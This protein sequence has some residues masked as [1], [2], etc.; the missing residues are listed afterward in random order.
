MTKVI[1]TGSD[2]LGGCENAHPEVAEGLAETGK[3]RGQ[4]GRWN[5]SEKELVSWP[6]VY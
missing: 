3:D 2:E 5:A 1:F 4:R 6:S